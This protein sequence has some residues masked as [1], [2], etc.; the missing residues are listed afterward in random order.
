M[1]KKEPKPPT[2]E[3]ILKE[4]E[5]EMRKGLGKKKRLSKAAREYLTQRYTTSISDQL[6]AGADWEKSRQRALK[7]GRKLGV[8][9][10]ALSDGNIV[11]AWAA[12]AAADAVA[13][14]PKCPSIGMGRW[15]PPA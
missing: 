11:L 2:V 8:V 4:F 6:K 10:K 1:A 7:V 5:T 15:C 3:S 12:E 14:D 9:A 13:N